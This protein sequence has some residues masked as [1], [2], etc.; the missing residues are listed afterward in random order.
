[1]L[2]ICH[3]PTSHIELKA[4]AFSRRVAREAPLNLLP[5]IGKIVIF[6]RDPSIFLIV[7]SG[8]WARLLSSIKLINV[9]RCVFV[10]TIMRVLES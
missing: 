9:D 10:P 7:F 6:L 3:R 4:Q 1:M 8:M 2:I 5:Q